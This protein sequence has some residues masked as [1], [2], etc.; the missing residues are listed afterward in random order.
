M[1]DL[2]FRLG[3]LDLVP[4]R[5]RLVPATGLRLRNEVGL[6]RHLPL[7]GVV[8]KV[9]VIVPRARAH[10]RLRAQIFRNDRIVD[11]VKVQQVRGGRRWPRGPRHYG[12]R[13]HHQ[14]ATAVRPLDRRQTAEREICSVSARV[15]ALN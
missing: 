9:I 6:R 5:R 4:R 13:S 12:I 2:R 1:K 3:R 7:D 10:A 15:K 11:R 8:R 14:H